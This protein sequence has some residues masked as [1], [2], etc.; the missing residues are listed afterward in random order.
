MRRLDGRKMAYR[1]HVSP[2]TYA[3]FSEAAIIDGSFAFIVVG[4]SASIEFR[5]A[6]YTYPPMRMARE[7]FRHMSGGDIDHWRRF[8]KRQR[9]RRILALGEVPPP[10]G[11]A[12]C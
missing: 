4:R 3:P 6:Y 11:E 5:L 2:G 1:P 10:P 8:C 12:M 9:W 7:R